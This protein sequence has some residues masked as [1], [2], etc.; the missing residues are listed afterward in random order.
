MSS[1]DLEQIRRWP[2]VTQVHSDGVRL[3]VTTADAETVA[4]RLLSADPDVRELEI[5]RA[6]LAE[7]FSELIQKVA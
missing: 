3:Q 2:G 5:A 1:I 7:A 6:G 4:R